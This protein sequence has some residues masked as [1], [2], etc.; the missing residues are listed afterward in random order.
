MG[1]ARI[2]SGILV[3]E[4]TSSCMNPSCVLEEKRTRM[5]VLEMVVDLSSVRTLSLVNISFRA[6]L[7]GVSTAVKRTFL[8]YML[9]FTTLLN[10]LVM[11]SM[12]L[13]LLK[14]LHHT[15]LMV[16]NNF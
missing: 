10:G 5:P 12:E 6:S 2:S 1:T 13:Q 16:A 9:M 11:S 3:L 15:V 14:L 8:V 7:P 4:G